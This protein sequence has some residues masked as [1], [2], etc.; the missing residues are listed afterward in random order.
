MLA[1]YIVAWRVKQLKSYLIK[2]F[3]DGKYPDINLKRGERV[4]GFDRINSRIYRK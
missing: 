3:G 2:I 1:G 4:I